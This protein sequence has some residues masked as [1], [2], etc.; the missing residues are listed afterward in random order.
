M[1]R[2]Q[3]RTARRV[4][5]LAAVCAALALLGVWIAQ[6][7]DDT[8]RR[9]PMDATTPPVSMKEKT[10]PAE[11]ESVSKK[12]GEA[13]KASPPPPLPY[14]GK[15]VPEGYEKGDPHPWLVPVPGEYDRRYIGP[16]TAEAIF[17]V[18]SSG[19]PRY[20]KEDEAT[21]MLEHYRYILSRGAV[22]R[23]RLDVSVLV[24]STVDNM[25]G[26]RKNPESAARSRKFYGLPADAPLQ[27][28]MDAKIDHKIKTWPPRKEQLNHADKT[29]EA[30]LN[31]TLMPDG[32]GSGAIGTG[33]V[34]RSDKR[35]ELTPEEKYNIS[36]HGIAPEGFRLRF[37]DKDENELP[38][39]HV[40]FFSERD[41]VKHW[42][43]AEL[44]EQLVLLP[45][46]M[47]QPGALEQPNIVWMSMVDRYEAALAEQEARRRAAAPS[48]RPPATPTADGAPAQLPA[49]RLLDGGDEPPP[50]QQREAEPPDARAKREAALA[51]AKAEGVQRVAEAYVEALMELEKR[52]DISS[53]A[54]E[55]L[56]RRILEL[57]ALSKAPPAPPVSPP[58]SQSA[59]PS[60]EEEDEDEP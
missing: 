60:S 42:S 16:Q 59:P 22:I 5:L 2:F 23:D 37:V 8:Q 39:D 33:I 13:D 12:E 26:W 40:P 27:E 50:V 6:Q 7:S 32:Q 46:F 4:L 14:S 53:E 41:V 34:G 3:M 18:I 55:K 38:F 58:N 28:L 25:D 45:A 49:P 35:R 20:Q 44:E 17:A 52:K 48:L 19:I 21:K 56:A 30:T 57:R 9:A 43:D 1:H 31:V 36:R 10:A 51:A 11:S 24:Y 54:R 15:L 47:E 29:G